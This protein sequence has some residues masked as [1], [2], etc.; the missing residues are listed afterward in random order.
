MRRWLRRL[1]GQFGKNLPPEKITEALKE[2]GFADVIDV[3]VGADLCTIEEAG[4]FLEEVPE[5]QPFMATS[6][7]PPWSV[8]SEKSSSRSWHPI[9]PWH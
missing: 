1:L 7:C 4:D 9:F 3:A 2:L 6:C 5:K 8:M